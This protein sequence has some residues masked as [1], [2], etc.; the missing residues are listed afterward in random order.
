M[1][2]MNTYI[3]TEY[4]VRPDADSFQTLKIQAVLD[5]CRNEGGK[6]VF[7]R[8]NYRVSSL[9]MWSDTTLYLCSG[10]RLEASEV[11]EDYEVY[12]IPD[13][14][15]LHTDMEMITQYYENRPW[16]EYRRAIISVYGGRNIAIVGEPD[17]HIDGMNCADPHGEEGYRGPH[18][19]FI[20]NVDGVT[21]SGYSIENC[22]NFMH[23]ID[24][25]RN[26]TMHNVSCIGGSDGVHLHC[27]VN[28]T[29][30][31]C[32][33]HTGDDCIAGINME[34][35]T[36][37]DCE[38]NT[39]C[40]LFRAGGSHILVE[41][42]R[43]WGP[44]IYPHRMTIV[45]DRY[46][47]SVRDRSRDLPQSAGRHNLISVWIHFASTNHPSPEPYHDITFRDCTIE[48]ADLF[49]NYH[50][51]EGTL[52][53]GTHLCEMTLENLIFTNLKGTSDVVASKAEPLH[54]TLRNVKTSFDES[55]TV[56]RLFSGDDNNTIIDELTE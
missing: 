5:R 51:D 44:G 39:S 26:I 25:C 19:I 21:L 52:Q 28:I 55:A 13:G 3:V 20:T 27:C 15:E 23:Q 41:N 4:G 8:G 32:I 6:V 40:D 24:S 22:G 11:C 46:T 18:G 29:I 2:T 45:P 42:C 47:D 48:N 37:R 7:P 34:N 43:M 9:R 16:P 14:M 35:L 12:P 33:F 17:S 30:E 50:A 1:K 36:V 31:A 54:I 49:L 56:K 10:A 38:L 53:S